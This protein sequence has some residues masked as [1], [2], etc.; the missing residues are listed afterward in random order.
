MVVACIGFEIRLKNLL[1]I[2]IG[3]TVQFHIF[4]NTESR[5]CMYKYWERRKYEAQA[6]NIPLAASFILTLWAP[7][8]QNVPKHSNFS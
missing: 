4:L 3:N 7:I 2:D 6:E 1:E 8:P 5:Y